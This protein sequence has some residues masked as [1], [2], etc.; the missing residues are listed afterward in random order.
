MSSPP[1]FHSPTSFLSTLTHAQGSCGGFSGI[2]DSFTAALW[3]LDY[4]QFWR[5]DVPSG[6]ARMFFIMCVSRSLPDPFPHYSCL[7]ASLSPSFSFP[8][9]VS[10]LGARIPPLFHSLSLPL[11]RPLS[12]LSVLPNLI[13]VS[14]LY[15]ILPAFPPS[16][17]SLPP[18]LLTKP[19]P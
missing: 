13:P 3:G 17:P 8:A 10:S 5:G 2:S 11:L 16:R 19:P 4:A 15:P 18:S 6:G 9:V 12:P 14:D 1:S 7:S